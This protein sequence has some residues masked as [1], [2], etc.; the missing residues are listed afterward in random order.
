MSSKFVTTSFGLAFALL[1]AGSL[2]L[3]S[4]LEAADHVAPPAKDAADYPATDI[5]SEEQVAIAADPYDTAAK[6]AIFRVDYLKYGLIPIRII[7]TNNSNQPISLADARINFIT[8]AKDKIPTSEIPDVERR[9][10]PIKPPSGVRYP[11]PGLGYKPG[12]LNK[13]IEDDFHAFEYS[14]LVVEPHSTQAGFLFYDLEDIENP[15]VGAQLSLSELR[16]ASGKELFSFEIPFNKYL[17]H[18]SAK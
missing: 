17:A 7:V 16:D 5:H 4:H 10:T 2:L 11:I 14:A 13:A 15:L 8:A 9:V 3:P 12:K 18:A 6:I 1:L